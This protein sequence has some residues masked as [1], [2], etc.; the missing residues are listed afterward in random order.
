MMVAIT[1]YPE[2]FWY[3]MRLRGVSLGAQPRGFIEIDETH[4][5]WGAV[6]YDRELTT[7]ELAQYE[8]EPIHFRQ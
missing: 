8:M 5:R 2:L 3:T 6:G 7:Q 4:G 1:D